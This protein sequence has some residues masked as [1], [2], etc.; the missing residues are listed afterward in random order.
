MGKQARSV[1]WRPAA[2]SLSSRGAHAQQ[3]ANPGF[4]SGPILSEIVE[5]FSVWSVDGG[6]AVG[7]T[8]GI[9]PL[10]GSKM[11]KFQETAPFCQRTDTLRLGDARLRRAIDRSRARA[12]SY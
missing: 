8:Q 6:T 10:E 2:R 4:E 12:R 3:L 11:L 5:Q 7:P 9:T 1:S